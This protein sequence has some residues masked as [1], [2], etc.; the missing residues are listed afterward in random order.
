VHRD[1]VAALVCDAIRRRHA[2]NNVPVIRAHAAREKFGHNLAARPR[3]N[4]LP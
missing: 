1:A 2:V 4:Y 3:I